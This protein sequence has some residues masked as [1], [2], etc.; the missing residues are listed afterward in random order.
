M[1]LSL[2]FGLSD[3]KMGTP[4]PLDQV[5]FAWGMLRRSGLPGQIQAQQLVGRFLFEAEF[6]AAGTCQPVI[7]KNGEESRDS[8]AGQNGGGASAG[9]NEPLNC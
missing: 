4:K 7:A 5:L 3:L 6:R 2:P 1:L 9:C 8:K